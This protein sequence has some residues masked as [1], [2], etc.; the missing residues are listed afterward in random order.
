MGTLSC[1]IND[2]PYPVKH[3]KSGLN[4]IQATKTLG[5]RGLLTITIID[6]AG[7]F[8]FQ[9]GDRIT[10]SDSVT[11]D[12]YTG[13]IQ[14]D[15]Q[16][17]YGPASTTIDHLLTCF[18][19]W[20]YLD[21]GANT[22]NHTNEYAGDIVVRMVQE[23]QP[24]QDG[25]TVAAAL[26][27]DARVA[28]WSQGILSGVVGASNIG[29]GDLELS[30]AGSDV[31]FTESTTADFLTG[32]L[33]NCTATSNTLVPTTQNAL[34]FSAYLPVSSDPSAPSLS[35]FLQA[36]IWVGT[37]ITLG[38]SDTLNFDVWV[39]D[40]N[41]EKVGNCLLLFSDLTTNSSPT[42][43]DQNGVPTNSEA[44]LSNYAVNQWYT[45]QI[46]LSSFSGKTVIAVMAT[47]AS[48]SVGQYVWYLKNIY[49]SS[50]SG[51]PFF[52]TSQTA[53]QL[54]PPVIYQYAKFI[55]STFAASV[56]TTYDPINSYRIS[57]SHSIDPVKLLKGSLITWDASSSVLIYV[58]YNGGSSWIPCTNNAILPGLPVGSN[59]AGLSMQLKEVFG[60][61][62]DPTGI[63]VI[64][65]V[66]VALRSAPNAT[67]SDIVTSFLTQANWNTGTHSNT[68]ADGSGNLELAPYLRDWSNN[69]TTGQT[70]YL[71]SGTTQSASGGVYT[72][73]MPANT[74]TTPGTNGFGTSSLDF[75]STMRDFIVEA[76]V[77]TSNT[78][79]EACITYRQIYWNASTNNTFG[80]M[81]GLYPGSPSGAILEIGYGS[82]STSDSY[83]QLASAH[84]S[85][86][87]NTFYHL[88]IVVNGNHHQVYFNN[89][90]TPTLDVVDSTYTQA[91][92]IGLRGFNGDPSNAHTASWDNVQL[93]QTTSGTWTGPSASV[94]SLVT[95]GG[96]IID[97]T[98]AGTSNTALAYA[99]VQSS[100][101][102]GSTYQACTNGGAIPGL[103]NGVSLSGKSVIIQVLLGTQ[104]NT[105]P[106]VSGLV[107]RVLGVYPGSSGTRSTAPMGIDYVDR[108]NQ[109]GFGTASDGQA[110][111]PTG[112][113]TKAV[114]SNM[115][116]ISATT[117][118]VFELLG[119]R[120]ITDA[121]ET[122][123]FELSTTTGM[124]LR[125]VDSTHYYKLAASAT[126]L[127]IIKQRGATTTTLG[128][129]SVNLSG[130]VWYYMRFRIVGSGPINLSGKVWA[131]GALEP[132]VTNGVM[133][134]T[135][136]QWTVTGTD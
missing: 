61:G 66:S 65:A 90:T 117:G 9:R 122:V 74:L 17:P 83:T 70:A 18:D 126:T 30:P 75:L 41:S 120:V 34:K 94:S 131:D 6:T 100:I 54:N 32:T 25:A 132:G 42:L 33:T 26:R 86:S 1:T 48:K 133:S 118:D 112:T 49:L 68:Q 67:K 11:G 38:G 16:T 21:K 22:D 92:G 59:I 62:N 78:N 101:D 102:G 63:P 116:Q 8:T 52:S 2:T 72:M 60:A 40:Q 109:S 88:K 58:T 55:A 46:S 43:Y 69:S 84:V 14:S 36:K 79:T 51:S 10:V 85:A 108:A 24:G 4:A 20:Y 12:F 56:V 7:V 104:T 87:T 27:R 64:D 5:V 99:F 129:A 39:S 98:E 128:T 111:A 3:D 91:G 13:F 23:G 125:Y 119:S 103:T 121:D 124:V 28:Q 35:T 76:D 31:T 93:A 81:V 50:H 45:R 53:P 95:C 44:D 110:W 136:P 57:T 123:K 71:P 105:A 97:W 113:G 29:D 37:P 47:V 115:L 15:Q 73:S 107:W 89:A 82:N 130:G 114:S 135:S 106:M 134:T 80:Y 127:S 77:K 19:K 96:S